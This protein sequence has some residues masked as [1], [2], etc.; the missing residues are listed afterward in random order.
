MLT[1]LMIAVMLND[2]PNRR[3][4]EGALDAVMM[5]HQGPDRCASE[6]AVTMLSG[7]G[8]APRRKRTR[9]RSPAHNTAD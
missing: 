5:I 2:R 7:G 1:S 4:H 9:R 6:C 8:S 3:A